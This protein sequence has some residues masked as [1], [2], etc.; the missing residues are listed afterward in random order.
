MLAHSFI[1]VTPVAHEH[2]AAYIQ[3]V[4]HLR[5]L[6]ILGIRVASMHVSC[7]PSTFPLN[8]KPLPCQT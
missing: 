6:Q 2:P 1:H 5:W 7:P 8:P 3:L 4:T